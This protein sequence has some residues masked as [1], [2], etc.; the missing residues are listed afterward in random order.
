M[1]DTV[2]CGECGTIN[3]AGADWCNLCFAKFDRAGSSAVVSNS[4]SSDPPV[5]IPS[6]EQSQGQGT[7]G[8]PAQPRAD[9]A[10]DLSSGAGSV[11]HQ[12]GAIQGAPGEQLSLID[13][14]ARTW[15]CRFCDTAVDVEATHC[16]ACQQSIY[17][18]FGAPQTER[19]RVAPATALK[20]SA[21]PGA[22][23][24][25]VGQGLLGVSI[26]AIVVMAVV[27]G[28][29]MIR[30]GRGS[31]G[32]G[33][34]FIGLG[35]WL[36]SVHDVLRIA[37]NE[38]DEVLLRPRVLSVVAGFMFMIVIAAAMSAQPAIGQ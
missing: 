18:S 19:P 4:S 16:P 30:A 28:F 7:E 20:W 14:G 25:V 17:D 35:T 9:A 31:Y 1:S 21:L 3:V 13:D 29:V 22:G 15:R 5:S 10:L 12:T 34:V 36:A 37:R 38:V 27:F 11:S 32:T 6:Q 26:A 8:L 23:H 2:T 33:V 24:R